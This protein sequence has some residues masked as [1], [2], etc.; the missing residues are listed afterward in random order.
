MALVID[1]KN[2]FGKELKGNIDF[3]SDF[4]K[5]YK[6]SD[7]DYIIKHS[8]KFIRILNTAIVDEGIWY[9]EDARVTYRGAANKVFK[10][11]EI[12]DCY[13]IITWSSSSEDNR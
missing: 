13:R 8:I 6:I 9:N 5:E 11:A 3:A 12:G 10:Y 1:A 2:T 4:I 7:I